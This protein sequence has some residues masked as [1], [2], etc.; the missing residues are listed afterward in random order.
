MRD[1]VFGYNGLG[2]VSGQ[3]QI[4]GG[5]GS[6]GGAS[7]VGFPGGGRLPAG[8]APGGGFG[9][10]GGVFGGPAGW[11]RMFSDAV[12]GQIAWLLP[13]RSARRPCSPCWVWRRDRVRMAAVALFAGWLGLYFVIFSNA[14]GIFHSYYTSVMVPAVGGAGRHRRRGRDAGDESAGGDAGRGCGGVDGLGAVD[15]GQPNAAVPRLVP[16]VVAGVGR[17]RDRRTG[18]DGA[19]ARVAPALRRRPLVALAGLLVVPA[20]WTLS[21]AANPTLNATLPQAGPREAR[22]GGTFGSLAFGGRSAAADDELAAWL[23]S[24]RGNERWDLV[25]SSAMSASSLEADHGLS[26]M[27]LGGFLGSDPASTPGAL[28]RSGRGSARCASCW[29]VGASREVARPAPEA[30]AGRCCACP[31]RAASRRRCP[32]RRLPGSRAGGGGFPVR[33]WPVVAPRAGPFGRWHAQSSIIALAQEVC[34]PV[35]SATAAGFPSTYDGQVLDCAG[36]ADELLVA[37]AQPPDAA[38]RCAVRPRQ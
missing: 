24:Q 28:R 35:T 22:P 27:A 34:T 33:G 8:G 25:T 26:V 14:K 19:P 11:L 36:M 21:E 31:G 29:S 5:G 2:R 15:R 6:R 30:V 9:G 7:P 23:S 38:P 18:G 13:A 3:G 16:V 32:G 37:A 17:G 10:P 4:G 1:L 20:A 12:G